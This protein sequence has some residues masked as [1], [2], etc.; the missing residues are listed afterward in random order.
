MRWHNYTDAGATISD[1][2]YPVA[3]LQALMTQSNNVNILLAGVYH[4]DYTVTD[5]NGN[6]ANASRIVIVD[7]NIGISGT[8]EESIFIYP[9]PSNGVFNMEIKNL[10]GK[11]GSISVMNSVG[12]VVKNIQ[13]NTGISANYN[14]D[15]G[16]LA[17]GIYIVK[18]QAEGKEFNK[19]ISIIK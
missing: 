17:S 4:Y 12:Q 16:Q 3:S 5:P 2:F 10:A 14:V 6:V 1:H 18:V 7:E 8:E 13:V 19:Y 9:N 15:L 11:N